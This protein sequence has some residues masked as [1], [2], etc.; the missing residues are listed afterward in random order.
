MKKGLQ[1][2]SQIARLAREAQGELERE[3]DRQVAV[4]IKLAAECL[5]E[6][7]RAAE[8]ARHNPHRD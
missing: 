8:P 5:L 4:E 1:R 2:I 6:S 3:E 7:H